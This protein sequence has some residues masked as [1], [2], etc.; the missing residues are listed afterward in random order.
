MLKKN[1]QNKIA[2]TGSEGLIGKSIYNLLCSLDYK[3]IKIDKLNKIDV[4]KKNV[5]DFL[6]YHKP[7]T[8][9]HCAAHPGGLS[10]K[11][12]IQDIKTN[13]LGSMNIIN[14]CK[15]NVDFIFRPNSIS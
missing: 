3:L 4:S 9:I 14:W 11:F 2:I 10:N 15:K 8:I 7:G 6:E 5:T 13:C 1:F 12:P